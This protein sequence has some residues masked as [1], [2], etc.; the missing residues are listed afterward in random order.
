[1]IVGNPA[2]VRRWTYVLGASMAAMA[3]AANPAMAQC[4][5]DPAAAGKAIVCTGTGGQALLVSANGSTVDVLAGASVTGAGTG[6]GMGAITVDVPA[7]RDA[8]GTRM[9]E[10]TVGGTVDGAAQPGVAVLSGAV[11]AN[12]YDFYG[13][14]ASVKVN[15]GGTVSGVNAITAGPSPT[16]AYG[17]VVVNLTNAGTINGTNG[18][19]L[20]VTDL[21]R[22]GFGTIKNLQGGT[23]GAIV[24]GIGGLTN[25]GVIDGHALSAIDLTTTYS[26]SV[27]F[28]QWSNTGT[29]RS[30]STTATIDNLNSS[31]HPLLNS[32]TIVNGGTGAAMAGPAIVV[33]N[34]A[35]GVISSAGGTAISANWVNLTNSGTI[36]GDVVTQPPYCYGSYSV[37]DSTLGT[38][39]GNVSLG[40]GNDL[41]HARYDGTSTLVTG[42][43]GTIDAG[44]GV[45]AMALAPDADLTIAT[46]I[47]L[48]AGF[49]RLRLAPGQDTTLTLAR[50]F[51][52]PAPIE[53]QGYGSIINQAE[54][55]TQGEAIAVSFVAGGTPSLTNT[56]SINAALLPGS[57]LPAV[58]MGSGTLTNA[59][60]ITSSGYG[61]SSDGIVANTGTIVAVN[62]AV[63][64]FQGEF[65]NGG[66][67]R[68]TAG[69][70]VDLNGN[71]Y[72]T[73]T[74]SGRIE[75]ATYGIITG[76]VLNNSGTIA[77][78]TG[79]GTAVGLDGYGKLNNLAGGVIEGGAGAVTG[80]DPA[81]GTRTYNAAVYNAGTINGDITFVSPNDYAGYSNQNTYVALAGGVL[82][83]DLTLG[84][85]DTLVTDLV[86]T[87]SGQ[88]AGI[89]GQV[90][91]TGGLLRYRVSG[92][93]SATIGSVRP[94]ATTGFELVED[95]HLTL[96]ANTPQTL[97]LVLAGGGTVDLKANIVVTNRNALPVV[98][99]TLPPGT[100]PSD[101]R[102]T[103]VNRCLLSGM[104][105]D[106]FSATFG[107]VTAGGTLQNE[108]TI[109]AAHIAT[110]GGTSYNSALAWSDS[111]VNN[112]RIELVNSH[113]TYN[114]GTVV[115]TGTIVQAEGPA[116]WSAP[117]AIYEARSV[118]NS[119]TIS[120]AGIAIMSGYPTVIVD[121]GTISGAAGGIS[122]DSVNVTNLAG[123]TISSTAGAAITAQTGSVVNAGTINGDVNL[124]Y[125]YGE[126]AAYY[127]D[128]GTLT[129]NLT[130]GGGDDLFL[131]GAG[132]TGVSGTIDMGG[133]NDTYGVALTRS[134]TLAI[135][136]AP[137]A[138]FQNA[139]VAAFGVDTVTTVTGVDASFA[140]FHAAG[141][142]TVVNQA[143][144]DGR[145][146][147]GA[148]SDKGHAALLGETLGGLVNEGQI[149]GGVA[150]RTGRL[151]NSG[152]IGSANLYDAIVITNTGAISFTNAATGTILASAKPVSDD[153]GFRYPGLNVSGPVAPAATVALAGT[154][155]MF[156][157]A[158][159]IEATSEGEVAITFNGSGGAILRNTGTILGATLLHGGDDN[160]ENAG[161]MGPVS[162]HGGNDVFRTTGAGLAG[163]TGL[164][165][166][167]E[168]TDGFVLDLSRSEGVV[169][170]LRSG[171]L[172]EFEQF[173]TVGSGALTLTDG[174]FVFDATNLSSQVTLASDALLV[175]T[176]IMLAAGRLTGV[177]GSTI[178]A[179]TITV[180]QRATFGSA[181]TVNGNLT[182]AG[183]LSPG[184]SPGT[185]TVNGNVALAG[186]SVS[187]FEVTPTTSD[188]LVVNGQLSTDIGDLKRG[189][190]RLNR[191]VPCLPSRQRSGRAGWPPPARSCWRPGYRSQSC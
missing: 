144:L 159:P 103:I 187:V 69:I 60:T 1:M 14:E 16:S 135:G 47:T 180:A 44:E 191:E 175:S 86:N 25:A 5:I 49:Q 13:T 52:A 15:A 97:P 84:Y 36:N 71:T 34:A 128:S 20:L 80:Y 131:Q 78:T 17:R 22:G 63:S 185:M 30:S 148:N 184:A 98:S 82:N 173:K 163:L 123:G 167:G 110:N 4:D 183:T 111:L 106:Y 136:P 53:L 85:G 189:A 32:G 46:A 114:V 155:L 59:G 174:G 168:G 156:D 138:E 65:D 134:G 77:A 12:A 141:D 129:G 67:I 115:N 116:N 81:G 2:R 100:E 23:I 108:G 64:I 164:V 178:S 147:A 21:S 26:S 42:I 90:T 87:G 125:W 119:G 7:T 142:G 101:A 3:V 38:I 18:I 176:D 146:L 132:S 33:V 56:G 62:T 117:T 43:T 66:T 40:R 31:L 39:N 181:G 190:H 45:N 102:L 72:L 95:A 94:F 171:Q 122:G 55:S 182:V 83:G 76:Y 166:G 124:A 41:V 61:V 162:L 37:I 160:V 9:A 139:V 157:N 150:G 50:G 91:T 104:I 161:I 121:S 73:G 149:A 179:S 89:E 109:R 158:R 113:A 165:N 177:A 154:S 74:N 107:V 75:G 58:S 51:A 70:G 126:G 105:D 118:S 145:L 170:V 169:H 153:R 19:A 10:I 130:F 8:Y 186:S 140:N 68:S 29:I 28:S 79:T 57:Y 48:P 127:T 120:T 96:T 88:F 11:P 112:G 99:A 27:R 172:T 6:G 152:T 93:T 35:S 151:V 143:A 24:G 54:I 133:G 137:F 92:A 188:K